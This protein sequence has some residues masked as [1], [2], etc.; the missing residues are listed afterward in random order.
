MPPT[1]YN[2]RKGLEMTPYEIL[3]GNKPNVS[4]FKVFGCK[5]YVLIKDARLS[6]F[7]TK[8]QEGIFV[9]Y[10][11]DSHAYRV[12]NKSNGRVVE[13][14]DVTFDED[15]I[16]L[17]GRSASCEKG[18]T[19]P[20]KA[21]ERMSV[22]FYRPQEL[23]PLST[24]E[25]PSS[26]QVEPSTPQGQASCIEEPNAS[27]AL[28]QDQRQQQQPQVH[29]QPPPSDQGHVTSTSPDLSGTTALDTTYPM[30]PESPGAHDDD[31]SLN[32]NNDGQGEDLNH[33]ED[34]EASQAPILEA[35]TRRKDATTRNLRLK[36]HSLKNILDDLKSKLSTLRQLANFCEHHAFVSM[37][38]P[39]KVD[40][41]L[42][43]PD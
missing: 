39:L 8:A 11:T 25:G 3:T 2:F 42:G 30:N 1:I 14:C 24:E 43:D 31:D 34:Q 32:N 7:D 13:T 19:I 33:D 10:A 18:D 17:K 28:P 12:F 23:P 20:P 9:G 6:K 22:G 16:S 35:N 4:Y 40:D 27:Q 37:V 5:C 21:I 38:E 26:T 29:Q 41:A 15:D 36:S